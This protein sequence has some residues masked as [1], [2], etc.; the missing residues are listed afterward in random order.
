MSPSQSRHC[1]KNGVEDEVLSRPGVD[2]RR[3]EPHV[4]GCHLD[5]EGGHSGV[6]DGMLK[7]AWE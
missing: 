4:V 2:L 5:E 3:E 6:D 7:A 1:D